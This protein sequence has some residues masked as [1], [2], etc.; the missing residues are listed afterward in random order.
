ML[1]KIKLAIANLCIKPLNIP[2]INPMSSH[3]EDT[4]TTQ[5][6]KRV[7]QVFEDNQEHISTRSMRPHGPD[8]EDASICE[9]M[10]CFKWQPDKIVSK[11]YFIEKKTGKRIR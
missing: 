2:I 4:R 5:S 11:P 7:R 9:N 6:I 1:K 10:N 3:Q 8:C